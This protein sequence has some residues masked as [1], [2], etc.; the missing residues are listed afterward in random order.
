[1]Q[2]SS[3]LKVSKVLSEII[4][5]HVGMKLISGNGEAEYKYMMKLM[6]ATIQ[7]TKHE[8]SINITYVYDRLRINEA[9]RLQ[10]SSARGLDDVRCQL[11]IYENRISGLMTSNQLY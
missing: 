2:K 11:I 3:V 1:M 8:N 10:N 6:Q 7:S 4:T 5:L 9:K